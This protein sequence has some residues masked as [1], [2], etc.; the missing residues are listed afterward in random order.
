[1]SWRDRVNAELARVFGGGSR[2]LEDFVVRY[3]PEFGVPCFFDENEEP[4]KVFRRPALPP[5][6]PELV[7]SLRRGL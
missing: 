4:T 6:S 2:K 1:M 3:D 5:V 7:E